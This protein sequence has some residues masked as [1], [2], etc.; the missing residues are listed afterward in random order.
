MKTGYTHIV[1][2]LDRSGSM[3]AIKDDVQGGVD[4]FVADQHA[5][6]GEATFALYTFDS[7]FAE[8]IS[9]RPIA[10][11]AGVTLVPR[12]TT[13]LLD[14]MGKSITL[15]GEWLTAK[16]EDERPEKVVFAI[17][18]DGMEN[19]S[20]EWSRKQVFDLVTQQREQYAWEFL[21]LAANQ[22]A[23]AT[24]AGM[25]IP[26]ASAATYDYDSGGTRAAFA[27]ASASTTSY[28]GGKTRGVEVP[29]K[30][31]GKEKRP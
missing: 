8:E 30:I 24:A 9:P 29:D 4:K 5:A 10:D 17:V 14:A 31:S 6:P 28:R 3:Q 11:V 22:D 16:S 26:Q 25:G 2:L 7:E 19:A 27:A 20:Q 21:F 23:I 15:T 18:T 1:M 12:G 13:A